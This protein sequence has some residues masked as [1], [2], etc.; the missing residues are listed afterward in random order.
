LALGFVSAILLRFYLQYCNGRNEQ[1]GGASPSDDP[2][3]NDED[4]TDWEIMSFTYML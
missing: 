2:H 1:E 3:G 4:K